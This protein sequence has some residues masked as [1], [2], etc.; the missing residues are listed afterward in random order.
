MNFLNSLSLATN[1]SLQLFSK[2][3]AERSQNLKQLS[4]NFSILEGNPVIIRQ[5]IDC[6]CTAIEE[7]FAQL[8]ELTL[9]F[10]GY[11][12]NNSL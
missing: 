3:I 2:R 12:E 11:L 7:R 8:Q 9:Q 4:M 1:Q 6:L 5:G 10:A